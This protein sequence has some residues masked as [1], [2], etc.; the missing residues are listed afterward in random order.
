MNRNAEPKGKLLMR[1]TILIA[2]LAVLMMAAPPVKAQHDHGSHD[3]GV[4]EKSGHDEHGEMMGHSH[5]KAELHQGVV[6]MTKAHHFETVY[7]PEGI[8][9]YAYD[10]KQG[11]SSAKGIE[12]RATLMF[13]S[14]EPRTIAMTFHEGGTMDDGKE[15][16]T[17]LQDYLF[18]P[19]DLSDASATPVRVKFTLN[20]LSGE[21][22]ESVEFVEPFEGL[23]DAP[24]MCPMHP[25]VWG[26]TAKSE[27]PLCG[28]FTSL[29]RMTHAGPDAKPSM[30]DSAG[31][32]EH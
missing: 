30:P 32:H 11:Q 14:G 7:M 23:V 3:Q 25:D 21:E 28:M 1:T 8:R 16:K 29:K 18:A 24:F 12:G 6:M 31:G 9:L 19:V 10:A 13:K 5:E 26:K 27:C 2:G 22:G 20:K 4:M 17:H 15:G